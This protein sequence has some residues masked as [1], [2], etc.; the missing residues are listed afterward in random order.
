[1]DT[2]ISQWFIVLPRA[3]GGRLFARD[4]GPGEDKSRRAIFVSL[5]VGA[6]RKMIG[7]V[8]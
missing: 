3:V 4:P 2:G 6:Q 5:R 8:T 1:M 7:R